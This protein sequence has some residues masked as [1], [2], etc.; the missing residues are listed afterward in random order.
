MACRP[1]GEEG[2]QSEGSDRGSRHQGPAV[3]LDATGT[4]AGQHARHRPG[5]EAADEGADG[6][7]QGDQGEGERRHIRPLV[8]F[9]PLDDKR[10][11]GGKEE[12]EPDAVK[13]GQDQQ[14]DG[15]FGEG[16]REGDD[17]KEACP[18]GDA[19]PGAEAV[20][21]G[22]HGDRCGGHRQ[23]LDGVE[24]AD[25]VLAEG[26]AVEIQVEDELEDAKANVD[27]QVV[28]QEQLDVPA[29]PADPTDVAAHTPSTAVSPS[30]DCSAPSV[31]AAEV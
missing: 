13:S 16:E 26:E 23:G 7:R 25:V 18:G 5:N 24:G 27:E 21:Q 29:E 17:E 8:A 2:D 19:A 6:G 31:P 9:G 14:Q 20:E 10:H 28:E 30:H 4:D 15:L 11:R 1:H 12:R 22:A 3:G